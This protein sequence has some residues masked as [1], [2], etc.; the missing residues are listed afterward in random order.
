MFLLRA[1]LL[2]LFFKTM[3]RGLRADSAQVD[4][5]LDFCVLDQSLS[6]FILTEAEVPMRLSLYRP[7][8]LVHLFDYPR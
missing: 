5:W 4:P 6:D 2:H 8:A 3:L 7:L 1:L